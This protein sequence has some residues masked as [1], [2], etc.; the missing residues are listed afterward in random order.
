MR[1]EIMKKYLIIITY[2]ITIIFIH[3]DNKLL[4]KE[5]TFSDCPKY[6]GDINK[7]GNVKNATEAFD[8]LLNREDKVKDGVVSTS[9]LKE[10]TKPVDYYAP[11]K[12]NDGDIK[13]AWVEGKKG[14]GIGEKIFLN[15]IG[16]P[17]ND[18]KA[19]K[20]N[21]YIVNGYAENEKL[22]LL[23]NRIKKAKLNIYEAKFD[24]CGGYYSKRYS[25]LML[26]SSNIII[27]KDTMEE[28][29]IPIEIKEIKSIKNNSNT[30]SY[31][32][33]FFIAELEILEIYKGTK[34]EDTCISE[35][36]IKDID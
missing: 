5:N 2:L 21:F 8:L 34:Y 15:I 32:S 25:N 30:D 27:L 7:R 18:F 20:I 6:E 31:S 17:T 11:W 9:F 26:N 36:N 19:M 22:F 35:F 28:Q 29:L 14:D 4:S 10:K 13:T 16:R 12:A 33:Y 3:A 24:I 1:K 23:N